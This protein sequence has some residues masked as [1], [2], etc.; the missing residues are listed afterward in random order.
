MKSNILIALFFVVAAATAGCSPRLCP[1]REVVT[2]ERLVDTLIRVSPDSS[3]VRARLATD[4]KGGLALCKM[5]TVRPS[6]RVQISLSVSPDSVIT[7]K[8]VIDSMGIYLTLKERYTEDITTQIVEKDVIVE[9]EVFRMNWWQKVLAW[10]GVAM[11]VTI[12]I[13][14]VKLIVRFQSGGV[15]TLLKQLLNNS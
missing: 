8:A 6:H 15:Q 9:K 13:W 2:R 12:V 11:L 3:I 1:S 14:I 4:I 7:A 10:L 5:E